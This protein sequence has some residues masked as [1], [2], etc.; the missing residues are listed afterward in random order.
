M[1]Q[2][3]GP[4]LLTDATS[5]VHPFVPRAIGPDVT[6]L[7]ERHSVSPV[8]DKKLV[9]E[10]SDS[11]AKRNTVRVGLSFDF[12]LVKTDPVTGVVSKD[13]AAIFKCYFVVPAVM[14]TA[15][16]SEFMSLVQA[17]M[18][19]ATVANY[20]TDLDPIWG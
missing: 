16:R 7:V 18:A 6:I 13:G 5:V 17:A 1:S 9:L 8:G 3:T 4:L 20:V 19:D 2:L 15:Q 14:T 10:F 12:P 11:S